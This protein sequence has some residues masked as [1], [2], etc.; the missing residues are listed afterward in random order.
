MIEMM[1]DPYWKVRLAAISA[2]QV[3]ASRNDKRIAVACRARLKDGDFNVRS[4]AE[5]ILRLFE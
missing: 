5:I 4:T 1:E 2:L 3:L